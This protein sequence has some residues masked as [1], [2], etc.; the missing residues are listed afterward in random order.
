MDW[1]RRELAQVSEP[2][3][4]ALTTAFDNVHQSL[5]HA[6]ILESGD[7]SPTAIGRL[8]TSI[9]GKAPSQRTRDTLQ[10]TFTEFLSVLEQAIDSELHSSVALFSLFESIDQQFLNVARLAARESS[11]QE[12]AHSDLL[13]SMW[14]RILGPGAARLRKFERN[15][16]LLR[17]VREKMLKNKGVLMDHNSRLLTLKSSLES[18]RRK[19]MSPLVQSVQSN[20]LTVEEQIR[21]LEDVGSHLE[22]IRKQ[23]KGKLMELL[24]GGPGNER[25]LIDEKKRV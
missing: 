3:T 17:D 23:Q 2:P 21:G 15:R 25:M 4:Q 22:G 5:T 11:E 10:K 7:G 16:D 8:V 9:F 24:F 13:A 12:D 6:G 14:T 18:L 1:A 19:L 20:S